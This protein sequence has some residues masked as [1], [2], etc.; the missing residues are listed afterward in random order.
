M[1]P[2]WDVNPAL[3]EALMEAT[4]KKPDQTLHKIS[5]GL[6]VPLGRAVVCKLFPK[7][8]KMKVLHLKRIII[9][10]EIL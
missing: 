2:I 5:W 6:Y 9:P 7:I 4:L 10:L 1:H 3:T 8:A